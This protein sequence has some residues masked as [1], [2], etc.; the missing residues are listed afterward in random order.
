[1][2]ACQLEQQAIKPINA[3]KEN[4]HDI[5]R[6]RISQENVINIQEKVDIVKTVRDEI[7][8][9]AE[10]MECLSQAIK[11]KFDELRLDGLLI[12]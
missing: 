2:G 4:L 12:D 1:M 10:T 5:A 8:R 9:D 3:K 11:E 6:D 7:I